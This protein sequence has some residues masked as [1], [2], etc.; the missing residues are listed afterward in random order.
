M[1]HV[2]FKF[3]KNVRSA[4][5][6]PVKQVLEVQ[7]RHGGTYRYSDV[8]NEI[9]NGLLASTKPGVYLD[10]HVKGKFEYAKA[11]PRLE[12]AAAASK[13]APVPMDGIRDVFED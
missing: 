1:R 10:E 9:G 4:G 3:S 7:F 12:Y 6:D 2:H 13:A 5:Y 8:P 11:N